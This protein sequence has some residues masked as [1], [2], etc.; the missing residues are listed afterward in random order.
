MPARTDPEACTDLQRRKLR[1]TAAHP[2]LILELIG[3]ESRGA[4]E[5]GCACGV[6]H[7]RAGVDVD[8][9]QRTHR[10]E[11]ALRILDRKSTRLNSSHSQISYA[12]FCLKKKKPMEH[13]LVPSN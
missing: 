11:P 6:P 13:I 4:F 8:A 1:L 2:V 9:D 7:Q 10:L 3:A 12:V 5:P